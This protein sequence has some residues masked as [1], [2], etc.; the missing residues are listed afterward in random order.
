MGR[1]SEREHF[2][3]SNICSGTIPSGPPVFGDKLTCHI[4]SSVAWLGITPGLRY[5][6]VA[7]DGDIYCYKG[8]GGGGNGGVPQISTLWGESIQCPQYL[9]SRVFLGFFQK[10]FKKQEN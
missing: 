2:S 8:A 9:G 6:C 5:F 7:C 3:E 1:L 4:A 10:F